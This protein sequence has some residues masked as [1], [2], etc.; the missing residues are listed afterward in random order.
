MKKKIVLIDAIKFIINDL[1][2]AFSEVMPDAQ[3]L[4][5]VDEGIMVFEDAA[6]KN[7]A[8]RFCNAAMAAEEIGADAIVLTCAHGIPFVEM[9]QKLVGPPVVQITIPMIEAAVEK[10]ETIGLVA[11]EKPIIEPLIKL[12]DKAS[13]RIEKSVTVKVA[14]CEEAFNPGSGLKMKKCV[15]SR[16]YHY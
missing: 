4:H 10:G 14:L 16:G 6:G 11:T 13:K 8:R 9:V 2:T 5:I 3:V 7:V 12:L 1:D 15:M